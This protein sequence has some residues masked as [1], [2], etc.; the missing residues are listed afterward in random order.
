MKSVIESLIVKA[1]SRVPSYPFLCRNSCPF[2]IFPH[3]ELVIFSTAVIFY[4]KANMVTLLQPLAQWIFILKK[5]SFLKTE[6]Y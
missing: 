4:G 3:H 1:T 6:Q 5:E 2:P